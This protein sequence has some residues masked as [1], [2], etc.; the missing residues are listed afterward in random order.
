MNKP[1]KW[2]RDKVSLVVDGLRRQAAAFADKA[3]NPMEP[4]VLREAYRTLATD[5]LTMADKLATTTG[6][7]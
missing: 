1:N 6:E 5:N 4:N 3:S 7:G 2:E